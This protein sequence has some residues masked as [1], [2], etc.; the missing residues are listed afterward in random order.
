MAGT[1]RAN[2]M[3]G[4]QARLT[5]IARERVSRGISCK[6]AMKAYK[7]RLTCFNILPCFMRCED[8]VVVC[9]S[10]AVT[11]KTQLVG[12]AAPLTKR[13]RK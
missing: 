4:R 10:V 1:L 9:G 6:S 5:K 8:E 13:D 12:A 7:K 2:A 3:A 11:R